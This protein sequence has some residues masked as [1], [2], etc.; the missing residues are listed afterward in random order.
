MLHNTDKI[1]LSEVAEV[2]FEAI[3]PLYKGM[4]EGSVIPNYEP[5]FRKTLDGQ[6]LHNLLT[7]IHHILTTIL[8]Q[9]RNNHDKQTSR[10]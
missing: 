5:E 8:L 10:V 6:E 1:T 2:L 7:T 3:R 4:P 9:E